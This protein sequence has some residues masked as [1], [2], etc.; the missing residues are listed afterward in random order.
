MELGVSNLTYTKC[1]YLFLQVCARIIGRDNHTH[2]STQQESRYLPPRCECPL[3]PW[4]VQFLL[5]TDLL[6]LR[7]FEMFPNPCI[8]VPSSA[9]LR[10]HASLRFYS[11][12]LAL[13]M[14]NC[15]KKQMMIYS[16]LTTKWCT[17]RPTQSRDCKSIHETI[18]RPTL[19]STLVVAC[20]DQSHFLW[21]T[22]HT[23]HLPIWHQL[24]QLNW[25]CHERVPLHCQ[26]PRAM[27][28]GWW[29]C[30]DNTTSEQLASLYNPSP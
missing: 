15:L 30:S 6:D 18:S 23:P 27:T 9:I 10:Y 20:D 25:N 12:L 13:S 17:K 3:L 11:G 5:P 24:V 1:V 19:H 2:R 7:V 28:C 14:P 8:H 22:P 29:F 26:L 21:K 16:F 4:K